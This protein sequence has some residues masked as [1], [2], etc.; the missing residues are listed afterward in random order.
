M[1]YMICTCTKV[2]PASSIIRLFGGERT[3]TPNKITAFYLLA[4]LPSGNAYEQ[5][6]WYLSE[7]G[8]I[9]AMNKLNQE[10]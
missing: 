5:E 3:A 9:T 10:Q 6:E 7:E 8:A 1:K 4:V 2:L